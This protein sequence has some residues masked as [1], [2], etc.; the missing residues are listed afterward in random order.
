M[1]N[2]QF[3]MSVK[4]VALLLEVIVITLLLYF[5][6]VCMVKSNSISL[7]HQVLRMK[8]LSQGFIPTTQGWQMSLLAGLFS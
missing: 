6:Q 3:C 7:L 5:P 2:S 8:A 1:K 4:G